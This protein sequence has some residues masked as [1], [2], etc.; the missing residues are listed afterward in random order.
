[1]VVNIDQGTIIRVSQGTSALK[2]IKEQYPDLMGEI[3]AVRYQDRLR[4]LNRPLE[5]DAEVTPVTFEDAAGKEIFLHSSA[6]LMAMAVK[7]LYPEAQL[8]IGPALDDTFYY[9]IQLPE[10]LKPEDL[11]AVEKR[12]K[13]IAKR[14]LP[15]ERR[16]MSR[17][18]AIALFKERGELLKV[19]LLEHL[20]ELD[21]QDSDDYETVS[22]YQQ[23]DFIDLCRGPHLPTTR[24]MKHFKLLSLAGAYWRGD[25][26]RQM[27][28]RIYGT[29]YPTA[30]ALEDHLHRYEEAKKRDHRRIGKDLNLFSFHPEAPGTPFWHAKGLT[31][32]EEIVNYWIKV[33]KERDYFLV[34]TPTV[35]TEELWHRSGH[36]AH[37]KEN[38]YFTTVDER[39]YAIKPMNCPGGLLIYKSQQYS[40]RDLPLKMGEL[41]FVHRYEKSGELHGL[42]RVRA[43]SVDDAHIFCLPEQIEDEVVDVIDLTLSFYKTFGFE[44][45]HI[46]L[47]TRPEKS[48]GTA[49]TWERAETAL[50]NALQKADIPYEL[51]PGDGAFYG[52]KIDFH[53]KDCLGRSW[54]CGTIQLDF[55]MPERFELEY[56]GADGEKHRPAMIH[57]A[58]MGSLERFIGLLIEQYAG[59]FPLWLAPVQARILPITDQLNDYSA[60]VRARLAA[61]GI[62]A[63]ADLRNEKIGRKIREAELEKVPVMLIIGKQE[64]EARTVSLRFKGIGDQGSRSVDEIISLMTTTIADRKKEI[65]ED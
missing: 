39:D 53:F 15:I 18:E 8:G 1:M 17:E 22:L 31:L 42:V 25:E 4:D 45:Y 29:S 26:S 57:R 59:D 43:F 35:L 30:E 12:M 7:E 3:L 46:E 61:A 63:E 28:Q 13:K 51:N 62:R 56:T 21:G 44:D 65:K 33:H 6:H 40:Y 54:Q 60:E 16:E 19:E 20:E 23:G 52:P 9:D 24:W 34:R 11:E 48:I 47:S 14:G 32:Y 41:G 58:V 36:Y 64:M 49:E 2:S 38:M 50:A 10:F 5:E 27:L 55:S 37:Y